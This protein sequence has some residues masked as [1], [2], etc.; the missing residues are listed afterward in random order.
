MTDPIAGDLHV[1]DGL[2][3]PAWELS[4]HFIRAGGPGG[5]HVNTS[6]S[7][8]QLRWNVERSSL[9]R[10]IK[11]RFARLYRSRLTSEGDIVIEASNARSQAR[12]RAEARRRLAEMI[13]RAARPA[14]KRIRT[15]PTRASVQR[16]LKAK[17]QRGAVKALRGKVEG[18]E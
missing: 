1:G 2:T 5:Q 7:A 18:E 9:P 12:N 14:K 8:V 16:R 17:K 6:A 11:A 3:V 4:E 13:A 10:A 15:R